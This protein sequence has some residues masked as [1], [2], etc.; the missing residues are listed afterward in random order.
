[1]T[2]EAKTYEALGR[3]AVATASCDP[4]NIAEA[5]DYLWRVGSALFHDVRGESL[6]D[7]LSE[8]RNIMTL[9]P[10]IAHVFNFFAAHE[11]Y[12]G[13]CLPAP[14]SESTI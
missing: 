3:Y 11:G 9:C 8:N 5:R 6:A 1:M 2:L 13:R 4:E 10:A 12:R 14:V 7:T